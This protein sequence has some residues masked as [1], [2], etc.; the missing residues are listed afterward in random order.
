MMAYYHHAESMQE[1]SNYTIYSDAERDAIYKICFGIMNDLCSTSKDLNYWLNI[2]MLIGETNVKIMELLDRSHNKLYGTPSP[3][4]VS[5]VPVKGKC[6]LLSGHD[7]LDVHRVLK[8]IEKKKLNINVYT[9]GELLPAH[10][11]PELSKYSNFVGHFGRAWQNQYKDFKLFPG[12]IIM[13]SNCL[14]P[15]RTR[16]RDRL[17]TTHSVGYDDIKH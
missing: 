7:I 11:Y 2:N 15:P 10:S 17:Y 5:S 14:M 9:H 4:T 8:L 13:T 3:Q 12:P 16:Y 1:E 6:V